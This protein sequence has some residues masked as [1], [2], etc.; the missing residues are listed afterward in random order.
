MIAAMAPS[1]IR[2]IAYFCADVRQSAARHHARFGSGP[3]FV[4]D[5][6]PLRLSR[7]RGTDA[8]L[9]HSSAYGQWGDVMVEFV[10]Q[11]NDG[12]SA[13]HDMYPRNSGRFGL[14]HVAIFVDDLA[15]AMDAWRA[16]GSETAFYG[17]MND[18][19]GFAFV[20][21][22][23]V[24]GHMTELYEGRE[25]LTDFYDFVRRSA[26][27]WDGSDPVRTIRFE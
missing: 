15:A 27:D 1:P 3:Y 5:N 12:P 22:R 13:F 10:Q 24:Y 18:G 7:H 14:H 26:Q 21:T 4:A 2:Q 20:D 8:P 19:F 16:E 11:N 23:D 9:D 6:I 17:E 25:Q